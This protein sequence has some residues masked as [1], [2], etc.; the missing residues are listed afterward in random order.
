[1]ENRFDE[2]A[3]AMA[4]SVSRREALRRVAGGFAGAALASLGLSRGRAWGDGNPNKGN[5]AC[6]HWCHDVAFPG[7]G[8]DAGKCTS[9][10]AK[11]KGPCYECGPAAVGPHGPICAGVCCGANQSCVNGACV[12]NGSCVCVAGGACVGG[13][14]VGFSTCGSGAPGSCNCG[15]TIEGNAACFNNAAGCGQECTASTDCAA[16]EVCVTRTCCQGGSR[17]DTGF[18]VALCTTCA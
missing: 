4:S 13:I 12:S 6:A 11:G 14:P 9:A 10:A 2:M 18:C 17:Q 1:V 15:A 3:K 5:D 8:P 7:P 16:N